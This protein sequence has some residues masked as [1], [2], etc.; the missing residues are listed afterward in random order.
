MTQ[1]GLVENLNL[2]YMV[3]WTCCM[4]F[5][6]QRSYDVVG[7]HKIPVAAEGLNAPTCVHWGM[8]VRVPSLRPLDFLQTNHCEKYT[9]STFKSPSV[10]IIVNIHIIIFKIK[11]KSWERQLKSFQSTSLEGSLEF[12]H[13]VINLVC[14]LWMFF[15]C[16]ILYRTCER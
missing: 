11:A 9:L 16:E 14:H 12:G 1:G 3:H 7:G 13:R 10:R 5:L 2:C 8:T 15:N 4:T 6:L